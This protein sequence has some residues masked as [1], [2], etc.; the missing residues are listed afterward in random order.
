V[1]YRGATVFFLDFLLPSDLLEVNW[2]FCRDEVTLFDWCQFVEV[3]WGPLI[4][5]RF[6]S[7]VVP[8]VDEL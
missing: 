7:M 5:C 1:V 3:P 4:D 6:S 2:E 8:I